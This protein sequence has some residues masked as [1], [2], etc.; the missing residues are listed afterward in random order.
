M[1]VLGIG[2]LIGE[3]P[4]DPSEVPAQPEPKIEAEG[5]AAPAIAEPASAPEVPPAD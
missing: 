2:R 3:G 5:V 4:E 1:L